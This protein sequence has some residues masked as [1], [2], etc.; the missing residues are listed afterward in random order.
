M[1]LWD[2]G[3]DSRMVGFAGGTDHGSGDR[4]GVTTRR[5]YLSS[6]ALAPERL[7][8]AVRRHWGI[9]NSLHWVL[10]MIFGEE[11]SRLRKGHGARN[12]AVVRHFAINAVPRASDPSRARASSPAG[13]PTN[14]PESLLLLPR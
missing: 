3:C 12:M 6:A 9:E 14:S 10:D 8:E 13:T 5:F 1:F 7:A 4:G 11:Q 2:G